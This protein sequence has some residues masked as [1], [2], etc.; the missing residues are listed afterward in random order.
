MVYPYLYGTLISEN[1][2]L[3][4]RGGRFGRRSPVRC[5][6][7]SSRLAGTVGSR[8]MAQGLHGHRVTRDNVMSSQS[9]WCSRF[10]E[11]EEFLGRGARC[12]GAGGGT[13]RKDRRRGAAVDGKR[14]SLRGTAH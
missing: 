14:D 13:A 2:F 11:R 12:T 9:A 7:A 4:G 3:T 10:Q 8:I 6:I 5:S 1:G